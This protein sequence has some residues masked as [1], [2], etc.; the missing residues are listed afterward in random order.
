M[1]HFKIGGILYKDAIIE[2]KKLF[3]LVLDINFK[4]IEYIPFR[5]LTFHE[6]H[7]FSNTAYRLLSA[8]AHQYIANTYI[9]KYT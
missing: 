5:G 7:A 1:S 8:N 6:Q 2:N 9:A 3:P 4:R